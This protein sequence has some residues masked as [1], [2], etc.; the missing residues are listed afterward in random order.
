MNYTF[1]INN[2]RRQIFHRHNH[3]TKFVD[4]TIEDYL[5]SSLTKA[6]E[7]EVMFDDSSSIHLSVNS[8]NDLCKDKK[9][10]KT[11]LNILNKEF[12][13]FFNKFMKC[14]KNEKNVFVPHTSRLFKLFKERMLKLNFDEKVSARLNFLESESA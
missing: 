10:Y 5:K 3:M 1:L 2:L 6:F 14:E 4:M 13:N 12:F 8:L 9:E 7:E 11:D